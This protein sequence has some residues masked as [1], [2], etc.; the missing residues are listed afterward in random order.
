MAVFSP[1]LPNSKPNCNLST[2]E[3]LA[4]VSVVS[5]L[6]FDSLSCNLYKRNPNLTG[7][8]RLRKSAI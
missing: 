8:I 3:F 2:H 6:F 7:D 4:L 1:Q 5:S